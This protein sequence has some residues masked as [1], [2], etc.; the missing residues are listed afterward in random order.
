MRKEL[1]R[2]R[3][4]SYHNRV[5]TDHASHRKMRDF[6]NRY[7]KEIQTAKR[8]HWSDY[9][10]EMDA[11]DIWTANR[12]LRNP[13]GDGGSP[14]I[15]M[16]KTRNANGDTTET[17]D[18]QAKAAL[19]AD[20]FFPPPPPTSS[21]PV[22]YA[23]PPPLSTP[24]QITRD[25]V[26]RHV[27]RL[28]PY[29]AYGPDEIANVVLQKCLD[30]IVDYILFIYRAILNLGKYY[31]PWREF[32]TV[33]LR[34]PGKPNYET[35]KAYRPIALL[36]TL[37]KVLTAIVAED[38]GR[39]VELHQLLPKT[40]FRGRPGC[41]TTDAV[42]YLVQRIK[43]AWREGKV[44]SILFLD[45]E[46][47]FPNAV[48]DRLVH[49]LKKRR[50]PE[51]YIRFIH[52]LLTGRRTKLKF[53]NFISESIA[54]LN[55]IGQGDPLSMILY[56]LYNADLLEIIGNKEKE[57][58]LGF[59]DD[60]M[61]MA[62]GEDLHETMN[63]LEMLMTKEERGLQ[64][65][66]DH[67]SRFETSKSA[68][69][70]TTRRS[71]PDPE[72]DGK[73]IPLDRP[74]LVVNGQ[75][76]QEVESFKYL[77]VTIDNQLRWN[78]QAQRASANAT[79]WLLQFRRLTK[80]STG[81]GS[82][83]MRQLYLAVALPKI[84]Y[85]IDIWY[86]PPTKPIGAAKS[87]GSVGTLRSL[88]KLQRMATLAITGALRSTPT[89]LLDAHAGVLPMELALLKTCHRAAV[90]MLTLPRSHPLHRT[91]RNAKTAP[92]HSH[93]GSVDNLIK[94]FQ[95]SNVEMETISPVTD[96][97]SLPLH[98]KITIPE[99]REESIKI[100]KSDKADFKI[101][102][103][104]SSY[105]GGVG[106]AAVMYRK[107]FPCPVRQLK[108]HLGDS[109]KHNSYEAETVGGILAMHLIDTSPGTIRKTVSIYVDNQ[110]LIKASTCPKASSTQHLLQDLTSKARNS[111]A[112]VEFKSQ[113]CSR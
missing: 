98:H 79:K 65:S 18:N 66:K 97:P 28:S 6:S 99:S 100:E 59:V 12:Y 55:G 37:A 40:H 9:L 21:V 113:R 49:N 77:G 32:N 11:N 63:W 39:L 75:I 57:D 96:D 102:T 33:V 23:Y 8:Q 87:T 64:W 30:I 43:E 13:V 61:L 34:K 72:N 17:N 53:D 92:P 14:R 107:G 56:I 24:R 93:L 91:V 60:I 25:Q 68:V 47:A 70:H 45:V 48:T 20:T 41:S 52:Q 109:S 2:L 3:A 103:D 29:K 104:G 58:S 81:V 105:E 108:A 82:K 42:H 62:I 50:I 76:I 83:L 73:R 7:G 31:D 69:L 1:N 112:K 36:S 4:T 88:Q 86:S 84:T 46:G 94:L 101:F 110:A 95:L 78:E 19:F 67:N 111:R 71:Q 10:E 54:I 16:L 22:K 80:P 106:A 27:R 44:V 90:R 89:D 38:I 5:L 85:G 15:P 35:P 74:A 51:V 26:E